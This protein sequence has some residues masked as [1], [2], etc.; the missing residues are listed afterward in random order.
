MTLEL[1]GHNLEIT[2]HSL[3]ND[4]FLRFTVISDNRHYCRTGGSGT[5]PNYQCAET[6]PTNSLYSVGLYRL[7]LYT[8]VIGALQIIHR[9]NDDDIKQYEKINLIKKSIVR[10]TVSRLWFSFG[11]FS[12]VNSHIFF[13]LHLLYRPTSLWRIRYNDE[14]N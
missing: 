6:L 2:E 8:V 11:F 1:C 14:V 5:V 10:V 3:H 4:L 12:H 9:D 7:T 13:F